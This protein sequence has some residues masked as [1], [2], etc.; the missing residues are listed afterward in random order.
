ME[1]APM[2]ADIAV[3]VSGFGTI[4]PDLRSECVCQY[5]HSV[6]LVDAPLAFT[7]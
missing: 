3:E 6:L 4:N 7:Q 5:C 1:T 2:H